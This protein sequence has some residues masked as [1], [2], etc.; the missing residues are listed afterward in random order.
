MTMSLVAA[1]PATPVLLDSVLAASPGAAS[2]QSRSPGAYSVTSPITPQTARRALKIAT[3]KAKALD[4]PAAIDDVLLRSD[5]LG[6]LGSPSTKSVAS[7]D[8]GPYGLKRRLKLPAPTKKRRRG[9]KRPLPALGPPP[10]E[11]RKGLGEPLD[12]N[13][14]NEEAR[15][16]ST[17]SLPKQERALARARTRKRKEASAVVMARRKALLPHLEGITFVGDELLRAREAAL[18]TWWPGDPL[19]LAKTQTRDYFAQ[20]AKLD[21]ADVAR[22]RSTAERR[23]LESRSRLRP[24]GLWD[25]PGTADA[26]KA[27]IIRKLE[28]EHEV[29]IKVVAAVGPRKGELIHALDPYWKSASALARKEREKDPRPLLGGKGHKVRRTTNGPKPAC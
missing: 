26:K 4:D 20:D 6:D 25:L 17:T 1:P 13:K 29:T 16:A 8:P 11:R 18:G 28:D 2:A 22:R 10:A 3:Y 21:E 7:F 5:F 27:E 15:A 9:T 23:E 24:G 19:Y 12:I 14:L